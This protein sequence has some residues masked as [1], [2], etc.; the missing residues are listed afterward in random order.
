MIV[1]VH[2][3]VFSDAVLQRRA[4]FAER[5]R[6]F[7]LLNPPGTRRLAT[8]RRLLE[9]MDAGGVDYAVAL[10]FGWADQ[11]LCEEQNEYILAAIR[12]HPEG[13]R[14]IPACSVQPRAGRAALRE[15]ERVAALGCRV[16]GELF[17]DGQGFGLDDR[18]LLAPLL[19][20]CAALRVIPLVHA[21]EPLGRDYAGKGET[22]PQRLLQLAQLAAEVAPELPVLCAHLGGG[23]P[24]YELM[25][26]VRAVASRLRY[27][28][29]AAAYLYAPDALRHACEIAPGRV[30]FGSDYPVIGLRRMLDFV[31]AAPLSDGDRESLLGGAAE[32]LFGP[33]PRRNAVTIPE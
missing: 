22:T 10:A 1:D 21:S 9:Q 7:G 18:A 14:L 8:V 26:E 29:G 12:A 32:A 20:A 28:T 30:L 31:R 19:E 17:P 11:A 24:Y 25:P 3:H 15:L 27:D 5:D 33:L 2:A 23:L 13:T 4:E 16:V 6:W